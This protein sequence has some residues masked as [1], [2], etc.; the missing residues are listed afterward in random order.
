LKGCS[1]REVAD[2]SRQSHERNPAILAEDIV[3]QLACGKAGGRIQK[4][5]PCVPHADD[6]DNVQAP[7]QNVSGPESRN[8]GYGCF[9]GRIL[10]LFG[11]VRSRIVIRHDPR[12]RQEA[13][14]ER[15]P[16]VRPSCAIHDFDEN[17]VR[18]VLCSFG[19]NR[20]SNYGRECASNVEECVVLLSAG[21]IK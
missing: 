13:E 11:N 6:H 19:S 17:G 1:S 9:N 10:D 3:K 12:D 4:L 18:V 2:N 15:E 16:L 20:Q 5:G 21:K 8:N 7:P 14:K